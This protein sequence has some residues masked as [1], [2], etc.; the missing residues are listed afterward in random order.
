MLRGRM[1]PISGRQLRIF[2]EEI[3]GD[4][5]DEEFQFPPHSN[6]NGSSAPNFVFSDEQK[7]PDWLNSR[8]Q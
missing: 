5:G 6:Q 4:M 7:F 1:L 8:G 2:Y 3:R